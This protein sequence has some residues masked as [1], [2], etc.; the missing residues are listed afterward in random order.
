MQYICPSCHRP[1]EEIIGDDSPR[2]LR[3]DKPMLRAISSY[4]G[5]WFGLA[6]VIYRMKKIFETYG[7]VEAV[8]DRRFK[9]EREAWAAAAWALGLR[10]MEERDYWVEIETEDN[11][12]D[13]R[14][15]R[16]DQSSGNN[17]EETYKIEVV[18]WEE[19]VDD[20]MQVIRQKCERAYPADFGLL[21]L[22]RSGKKCDP[23][24]VM[25]A[26]QAIHV[27]FAE[28]WIVG[29]PLQDQAK[30][31]MV[32]LSPEGADVQ[33]D[34]SDAVKRSEKQPQIMRREQRGT[35]TEFHSLGDIYFPIP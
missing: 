20:L 22:G 18:D 4:K 14:V 31:R 13:A 33:F 3:C 1:P 11:T 21:V 32:R 19:H 35:G 10:E 17:V 24:A 8:A 15:H 9:H 28:I 34:L 29:R 12:P 23:N 25:Q 7:N 27:P 5:Y 16:L 2:C 6:F 26:I 30:V